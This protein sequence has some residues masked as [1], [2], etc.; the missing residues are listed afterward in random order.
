MPFTA[1]ESSLYGSDAAT[2]SSEETSI[3]VS[4]ILR[5]RSSE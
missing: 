4:S 5:F 3:R 1:M 2:L